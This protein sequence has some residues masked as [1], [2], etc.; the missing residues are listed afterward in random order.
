M[1]KVAL[2]VI[3]MQKNCKESTS[4]RVSFEKAVEYINEISEY[5]RKKKYP[6]V[7]IQDIEAG[8]AETDGFKCVE[9]LVVSD[10]DLF[11]HKTY[12]NAFWKTE[13]DTIL[14]SEGVDCIVISGFAAEHCVLFTYNGAIERGYNTFLLQNGIAGFDDDEIKGIQSLRSVVSYGALEYFLK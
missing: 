5:F 1:S 6:V 2:L 4:C 7:I 14:K 13:L 3:D 12:S 8:G 9:E 10:N 11:V